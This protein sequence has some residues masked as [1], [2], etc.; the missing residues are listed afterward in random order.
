[1]LLELN[2]TQDLRVSQQFAGL[3]VG[4]SASDP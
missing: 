2:P 3:G 4:R 1:V